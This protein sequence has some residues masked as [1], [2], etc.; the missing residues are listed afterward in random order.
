MNICGS[1]P[2]LRQEDFGW[3]QQLCFMEM[4]PKIPGSWVLMLYHKHLESIDFEIY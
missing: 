3:V 4:N 1:I 2:L